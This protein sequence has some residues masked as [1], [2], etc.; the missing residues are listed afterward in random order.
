MRSRGRRQPRLLKR[1]STIHGR[2]LVSS[3]KTKRSG[4]NREPELELFRRRR[5]GAVD[6]LR[7]YNRDKV[8]PPLKEPGDYRRVQT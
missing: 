6:Y 7:L 3:R 2:V 1:R 4:G 5:G 8:Q